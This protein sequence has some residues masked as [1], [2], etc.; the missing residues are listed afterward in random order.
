M[1]FDSE[2]LSKVQSESYVS[3]SV[4]RRDTPGKGV[5]L[6][7]VKSIKKNEIVSISGGIVLPTHTWET[8]KEGFG[9]YAYSIHDDFL[10]VRIQRTGRLV[11][12]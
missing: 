7:A 5:G 8:I 9:D 1:K 12:Q 10:I 11:K 4:E 2:F 6:F 3:P